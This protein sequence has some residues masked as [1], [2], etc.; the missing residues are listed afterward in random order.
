MGNCAQN[1]TE[2]WH[3]MQEPLQTGADHLL[4]FTLQNGPNILESR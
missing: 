2:M 4:L 3:C 1:P